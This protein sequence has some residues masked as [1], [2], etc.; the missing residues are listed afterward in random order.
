MIAVQAERDLV[1]VQAQLPE[2]RRRIWLVAAGSLLLAAVAGFVTSAMLTR[3]ADEKM[4]SDLPV[5]E[6]FDQYREVE[7]LEFLRM[8]K[9]QGFLEPREKHER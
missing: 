2:R 6:N 8:L 4:L 9:T 1:A 5:I 7:D 3:R